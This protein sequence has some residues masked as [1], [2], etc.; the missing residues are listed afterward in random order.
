MHEPIL[1]AGDELLKHWFARE[2]EGC[3]STEEQT[4]GRW[5][6][7]CKELYQHYCNWVGTTPYPLKSPA[8]FWIALKEMYPLSEIVTLGAELEKH[9]FRIRRK[10]PMRPEDYERLAS[11]ERIQKR[12]N[13][14]FGSEDAQ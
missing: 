14:K 6:V 7:N 8:E 2:I 9:F 11:Q 10:Y 1:S 13:A 4:T 12:F 3:P 5:T